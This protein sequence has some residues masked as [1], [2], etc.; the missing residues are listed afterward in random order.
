MRALEGKYK[1]NALSLFEFFPWTPH[2]ETLA[3]FDR[4]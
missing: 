1:L 4:I 2:V 3:V